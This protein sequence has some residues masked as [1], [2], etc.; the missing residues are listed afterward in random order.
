MI[1]S[2]AVPVA[3]VPTKIPVPKS[4]GVKVPSIAAS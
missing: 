4:S 3:A 1:K 2:P